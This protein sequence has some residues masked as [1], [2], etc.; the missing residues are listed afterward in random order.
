ML[1]FDD[2]AIRGKIKSD[3]GAA[4]GRA[5]E[6]VAFL[7]FPDL[8]QSVRDDVAIVRESPLVAPGARVAGFVY[9]VK[10]GR[11]SPVA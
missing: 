9:D 6:A 10:T 11:L 5:A 7:P 1:T 8:E 2:A 3:L 4:A